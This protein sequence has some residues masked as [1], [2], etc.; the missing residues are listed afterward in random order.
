MRPITAAI[1]ADGGEQQRLR[2]K[3]VRHADSGRLKLCP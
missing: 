1:A 3:T 2:A